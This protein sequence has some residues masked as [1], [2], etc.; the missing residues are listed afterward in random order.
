[1]TKTFEARV[2]AVT[3][4]PVGSP[5]YDEQATTVSINDE[6]GRERIVP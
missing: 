1:M 2:T 4:T 5:I 6:A 3:I